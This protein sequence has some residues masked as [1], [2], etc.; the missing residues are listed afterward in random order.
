MTKPDHYR[1]KELTMEPI[2]PTG[3]T[4]GTIKWC[5]VV[6]G[7]TGITEQEALAIATNKINYKKMTITSLEVKQK[8]KPHPMRAELISKLKNRKAL[9]FVFNKQHADYI[10]EANRRHNNTNYEELLIKA[11]KLIGEGKLKLEDKK[12]WIWENYYKENFKKQL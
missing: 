7:Y 8:Q 3:T 10:V 5:K 11:K 9:P 2:F 1:I 4:S 12:R 6:A